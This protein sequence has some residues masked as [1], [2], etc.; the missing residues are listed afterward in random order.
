MRKSGRVVKPYSAFEYAAADY[1]ALELFFPFDETSGLAFTD[2]AGGRVWSPTLTS[3]EA[4]SSVHS[5]SGAVSLVAP[6]P[7]GSTYELSGYMSGPSLTAPGTS[8][9]AIVL[10]VLGASPTAGSVD[11]YW[12]IR[13]GNEADSTE[14]GDTVFNHNSKSDLAN[15]FKI[16]EDL[17]GNLTAP[18]ITPTQ[19]ADASVVALVYQHLGG[20]SVRGTTIVDSTST[21]ATDATGT[22]STILDGYFQMQVSSSTT[23]LTQSV[24][25]LQ[26]WLFDALP[27]DITS[28]LL[29]TRD[30]ALSGNKTP[31]PGWRKRT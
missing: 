7:W 25:T 21:G 14:V 11:D 27:S 2:A 6:A 24:Y 9:V 4:A 10:A 31:Y 18:A 22:A 12:Y 23:G 15:T 17:L 30:S 29:W 16:R 28:A 1:P 8:K 26:Y 3:T 13:F 20:T 19:S 5:V